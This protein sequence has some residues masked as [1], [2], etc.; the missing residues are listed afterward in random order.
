M[1]PTGIERHPPDRKLTFVRL[2]TES[3]ESVGLPE[4]I[5]VTPDSKVE[6]L[7]AKVLVTREELPDVTALAVDEDMW[8]KVRIDGAEGWIHTAEDF[9]ALGLHQA[10]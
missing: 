9:N 3:R 1:A 10:G 6:F 5:V 7:T 4:H 8:L 2:F